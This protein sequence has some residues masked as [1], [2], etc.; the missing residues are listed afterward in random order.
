MKTLALVALLATAAPAFANDATS[1]ALPIDMIAELAP[2]EA[3][4]PEPAANA[5]PAAVA[6]GLFQ[7]GA[8]DAARRAAEPLALDGDGAMAVLLAR[9]HGEGLSTRVDATLAL[10]WLERASKNGNATAQHDLAIRRLT[11]GGDGAAE[12]EAIAT[13][14][15]LARDGHPTAAFDLAQVLLGP[16]RLES[17]RAEGEAVL[18]MA[19]ENGLPQAQH[20]LARFTEATARDGSERATALRLLV[21]AARSGLPDAQM[22]LGDWLS[23]GRVGVE[24]SEA[25]RGW[26]ERAARAGQPVAIARLRRMD[27]AERADA[28]AL[29]GVDWD[30]RYDVSARSDR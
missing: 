27:A 2:N 3:G 28:T 18:R 11:S 10:E 16:D 21:A 19:A 22:E 30:Q 14:R 6:Y 4:G 15:A 20:A 23:S 9:I 1:L 5:S 17:E 25:A 13:L 26:I 29:P 7:R 8:W 24:D 12:G